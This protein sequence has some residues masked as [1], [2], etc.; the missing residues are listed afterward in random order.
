MWERNYLQAFPQLKVLMDEMIRVTSSQ[1]K[2]PV[3]DVLHNRVCAALAYHMA[4]DQ[5]SPARTQRLGA[6]ADLLHNI[7][8]E[9]K[10]SVLSDPKVYKAVAALTSRLKT[11][12]KLAGSPEF[13]R[14]R[15]VLLNPKVS[16]NS[17]LIHHLTS[18]VM[19]SDILH[20][21]GGYTP[22]EMT[23]IETAI[24]EHST[25]YWYFRASVD[26]AAG[27]KG[28]WRTV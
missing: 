28:A 23:D 2:D 15:E 24:V 4:V 20:R 26:E 6:A 17:G 12:G 16:D 10:G 22:D 5:Q 1:L 3:Q 13:F 8:K 18:A 14:E 21:L 7:A 11:S 9:D 25:G 27:R 19:G